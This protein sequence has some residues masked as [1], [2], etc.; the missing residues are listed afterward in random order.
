[1]DSEENCNDDGSFYATLNTPRDASDDDIKR[2]FRQLAQA[3][4]P[5]KHTDPAL[6]AHAAAQFTHLQEAYEV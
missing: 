5:D 2:A 6:K 3:Y 4:H 1:M